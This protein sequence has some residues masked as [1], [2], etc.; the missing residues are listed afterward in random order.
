MHAACS[1]LLNLLYATTLIPQAVG[2]HFVVCPRLLPSVFVGRL[3]P[4]T[5]HVVVTKDPVNV[6]WQS[7][8]IWNDGNKFDS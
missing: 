4:R 5:R 7:S 8:N 6:T 2:T 3:L 1:V